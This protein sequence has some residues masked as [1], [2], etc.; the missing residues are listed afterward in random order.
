MA[1]VIPPPLFYRPY[2]LF[3]RD[4]YSSQP[5]TT[6][7]LNSL[8]LGPYVPVDISTRIPAPR[9]S[10]DLYWIYNDLSS[11]LFIAPPFPPRSS[12]HLDFRQP[13]RT[14][15]PGLDWSQPNI[16]IGVLQTAL[17][18]PSVNYF[19]LD[20]RPSA[21]RNLALM[22]VQPFPA[23]LIPPPPGSSGSYHI[24]GPRITASTT[25]KGATYGIS[26]PHITRDSPISR[27]LS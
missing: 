2:R 13:A 12:V 9:R 21:Q 25:A 18:R 19:H 7:L 3:P 23:V 11:T 22:L 6:I 26:G 27:D 16:T 14:R 24:D 17:P 15:N 10:P 20:S 8:S 1:T 5:Q 4:I